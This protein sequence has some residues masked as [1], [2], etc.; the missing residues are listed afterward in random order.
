MRQVSCH[1]ALYSVCNTSYSIRNLL[2]SDCRIRTCNT[3][4]KNR[5]LYRWAKSHVCVSVSQTDATTSLY[6]K[7]SWA[8][9]HY[10]F[11]STLNRK[12]WRE[13]WF[14]V[15]TGQRY[16][17]FVLLFID[18]GRWLPP[19]SGWTFRRLTLRFRCRLLR[20]WS[21]SRRRWRPWTCQFRP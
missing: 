7:K 21:G 19:A 17:V 13:L 4:I 11:Y 6:K 15:F 20:C 1:V 9:L 12:M 14:M 2:R 18:A 10:L 5:M 8:G 16:I 3:A